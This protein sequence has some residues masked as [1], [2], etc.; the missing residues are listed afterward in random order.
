VELR[1]RAAEIGVP[2][3]AKGN[4]HALRLAVQG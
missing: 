2:F 3:L 4:L 1:A